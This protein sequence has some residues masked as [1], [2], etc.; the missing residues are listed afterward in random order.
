MTP[1]EELRLQCECKVYFRYL[2]GAEPDEYVLA[3]YS[4]AHGKVPAYTPTVGFDDFLTRFAARR[5]LLTRLADSYACLFAPQS[6]LRRKLILLLAILES[7]RHSAVHLDAVDSENRF[8]LCAKALLL[9]LRFVLSLV[10]GLVV[11]LPCRLGQGSGRGRE[12]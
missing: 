7:S 2:S 10:A 12:G 8:L 5:P 4:E 11:L 9:G 1:T 3:K 6:T